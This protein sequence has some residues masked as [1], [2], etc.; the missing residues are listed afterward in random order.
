MKRRGIK[1]AR[2][3]QSG[4][5]REESENRIPG[6]NDNDKTKLNEELSNDGYEQLEEEYAAYNLRESKRVVAQE[7]EEEID[8]ALVPPPRQTKP[9][10]TIEPLLNLDVVASERYHRVSTFQKS[11]ASQFSPPKAVPQAHPPPPAQQP[12]LSPL[13]SCHYCKA[14][15]MTTALDS[16]CPYCTHAR[17]GDCKTYLVV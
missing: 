11:R 12:S 1:I 14:A 10:S 4:T 5:A 8:E 9:A 6:Y 13:W 3:F 15:G 7:Q 17:C 2:W 16:M